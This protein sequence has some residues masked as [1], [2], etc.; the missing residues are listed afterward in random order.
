MTTPANPVFSL[1]A[2]DNLF[3][4]GDAA[5]AFAWIQENADSNE[6][7]ASLV[8]YLNRHNGLTVA[9]WSA[10]HAASMGRNVRL[11]RR[12]NGTSPAPAAPVAPVEPA[13]PAAIKNKRI[14]LSPADR[15]T[16]RKAIRESEGWQA[17]SRAKGIN[18]AE[19][20]GDKLFDAADACGVDVEAALAAGHAAIKAGNA[21]FASIGAGEPEQATPAAAGMSDRALRALIREIAKQE[22]EDRLKPVMQTVVVVERAGVQRSATGDLTHPQ[23][24]NLAR[25]VVCRDFSGNRLNVLLVGPTGTGKSFACKQLADALGLP[26]FFQSQADESFALVGYE[27][28]NG[29]MK[30][31]PFVTAFRDGGVCLLDELDRYSPKALTALN[32]ALANG[33]MT[34]DNGE[35]IN[36][37]DDFICVGAANTTGMGA[38]HDFTAAE[39]LDL[40]TISRF[41]VRLDW[42]VCEDTENKIAAAK[43]DDADLARH[44]L[45]EIRKVRA[46]CDRLS[47]PYLADQRAV[48]SGAN[49]LAAGMPLDDVRKVT[50]LAPLDADQRAAVLRLL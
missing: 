1:A 12:N 46:A 18:T 31:T 27:R 37:H 10:A 44:W 23:F 33:R 35:V 34:L 3:P 40:S 17:Y 16:A 9:Q 21:A 26:F 4:N 19:L 43:A 48:E 5:R 8:R 47:L 11:K 36:R 6:F 29:S 38:T 22:A 15:A 39:K 42:A 50:Y 30:Y 41:S 13:A 7:A 45:A 25:A 28:V 32:A 49:L 20:S 2:A 14:K 24:P